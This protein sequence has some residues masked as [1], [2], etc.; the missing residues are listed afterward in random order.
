M[1][2]PKRP[3]D[4]K[5]IAALSSPG[6]RGL[7]SAHYGTV[8]ITQTDHIA[9][10]VDRSK[11]GNRLLPIGKAARI[12]IEIDSG[13]HLASFASP[14]PYVHE[15]WSSYGRGWAFGLLF[16]SMPSEADQ[17]LLASDGVDIYIPS[18]EQVIAIRYCGQ[19]EISIPVEPETITSL[20]CGYT[21]GKIRAWMNREP[22]VE[23]EAPAAVRP[24]SR[25]VLGS[26]RYGGSP[27]KGYFG[28][29][30]V[31]GRYEPAFNA[32]LQSVWTEYASFIYGI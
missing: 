14:A 31:Y 8:G 15:Y 4:R 29:L 30:A 3:D 13:I 11:S 17:Y 26:D 23:T 22:F 6:I 7:Y 27:W 5:F 18:G 25:V 10:F 12:A 20:F 32:D 2:I 24:K 9:D 28:E 19:H 16:M 1:R 21:G